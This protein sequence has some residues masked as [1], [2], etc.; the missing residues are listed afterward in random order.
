MPIRILCVDD[1]ELI[2]EGVKA[3]IEG[4]HDMEV[5][6]SA[7]TGEHGVEL[8]RKF[9]PDV[10]LMDLRLPTISGIEATKRLRAVDPSAKIIVLTTYTSGSEIAAALEAGA[11][12][13]LL[14]ESL[15][16]D[17]VRLVRQVHAGT[18]VHGHHRS[19]TTTADVESGDLTP[20]ELDVLNLIAQGLRNKEIAT[21]LGVTEETVKTHVKGLLAKLDARDR[22]AAI[23]IAVSRGLLRL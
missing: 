1:H 17:L 21:L 12:S 3:I 20:R 19:F 9:R 23:S 5:V 11:S 13:Y 6:A 16:A 8:Y 7:A 22:T 18:H 15:G 14:K 10:T 4:Q 2:R